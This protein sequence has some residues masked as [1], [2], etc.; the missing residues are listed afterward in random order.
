MKAK[1][2]FKTLSYSYLESF[3]TAFASKTCRG[4]DFALHTQGA[5]KPMKL[6]FSCAFLH[7][8][9]QGRFFDPVST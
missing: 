1:V 7:R 9:N 3:D 6:I 8:K 2:F 4:M 5:V